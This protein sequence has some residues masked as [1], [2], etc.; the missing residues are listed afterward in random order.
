MKGKITELLNNASIPIYIVNAGK[1]GT[2][3]KILLNEKIESTEI[4]F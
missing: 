2:L 4:R 1:H 3:K